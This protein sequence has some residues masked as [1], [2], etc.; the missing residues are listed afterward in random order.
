MIYISKKIER[1]IYYSLK[2]KGF[3]S[4]SFLKFIV[5]TKKEKFLKKYLLEVGL[6]KINK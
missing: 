6:I 1:K 5:K 3:F 4:Y 2:K